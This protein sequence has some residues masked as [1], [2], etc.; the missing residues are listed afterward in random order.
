LSESEL[1]L[2]LERWGDVTPALYAFVIDSE[3]MYV[4]KTKRT[5]GSRLYGYLKG[6]GS[7]R[8]NIRVRGE[9]LKALQTVDSVEIL[10]F[11][12][13]Q[14][15]SLGPFRINL[16]AG[17]EDDL[18]AQL[19][20]PWNGG[21][22][23]GAVAKANTSSKAAHLKAVAPPSRAMSPETADSAEGRLKPSFPVTIGKTYHRQGFF[24]VPVN[25]ERYFAGDGAAI[26]IALPGRRNPA[27]GKL[28]RSVNSTNAP[29]VM[30]GTQ[31]R[32]WLQQNV[33]IGDQIRV[34]AHGPSQ[35]E[36][37]KV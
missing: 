28:N 7:Q 17:L 35:I 4:G 8:T 9:I 11:Q 19:N 23:P 12:D 5:L 27:A 22:E 24:N 29:R 1:R 21:R 13:R 16:S 26:S 10:G 32:D 36:I 34:V 3:I 6:G 37:Q 2:S 20:P 14:P 30:G 18:I 31:L 15:K 33:R 25:F